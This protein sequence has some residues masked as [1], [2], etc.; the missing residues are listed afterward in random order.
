[1][2]GG[3]LS[4]I[5]RRPIGIA[6]GILLPVIV[7]RILLSALAHIG[8]EEESAASVAFQRGAGYLDAADKDCLI[9]LFALAV[10]RAL[11]S[12]PSRAEPTSESTLQNLCLSVSI[13][14]FVPPGQS[15]AVF[16]QFASSSSSTRTN[17]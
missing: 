7:G 8:Q 10:I 14:G 1:L 5:Q 13:C 12:D 3:G 2:E 15:L 9:S 6:H 4:W 16:R 11:A 17:S